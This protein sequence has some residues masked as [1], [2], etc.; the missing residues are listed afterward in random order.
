MKEGLGNGFFWFCID[1]VDIYNSNGGV[2]F[3]LES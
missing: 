3:E 1:A 2:G